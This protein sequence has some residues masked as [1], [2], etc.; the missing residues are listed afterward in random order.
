[1]QKEIWKDVVG[2]EEYFKVSEFGRIYSKRT[3]KELKLTVG[4]TGYKQFSTRFGGRKGKAKLFKVHILV[5]EAFNGQRPNQQQIYALHWDDNKLNNHYTNLRWGSKSEN[6]RDLIRNGK[7]TAHLNHKKGQDNP[8]SKLTNEDVLDIITNFT[9][10]ELPSR[11]KRILFYAEKFSVSY[12]CIRGIVD[13]LR[14]KHLTGA[15]RL[16]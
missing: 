16:D 8:D 13:G 11:G 7:F 12:S 2:Y 1:M 9:E 3:N 14:W 4:K 15:K 10:L 6:V 5:C